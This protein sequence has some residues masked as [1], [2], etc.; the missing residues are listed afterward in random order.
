MV[1]C[2]WDSF[3]RCETTARNFIWTQIRTSFTLPLNTCIYCLA[4]ET[5]NIKKNSCEI[6]FAHSSTIHV[7]MMQNAVTLANIVLE[8]AGV[9]EKTE[10]NKQ[11]KEKRKNHK[12]NLVKQMSAAIQIT[13]N[14]NTNP[15]SL[16]Y[17]VH[18]S[19]SKFCCYKW[20][21]SSL[22]WFLFNTNIVLIFMVF[23]LLFLLYAIDTMFA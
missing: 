9:L 17:F 1:K 20:N 19:P 8:N 23:R 22:L 5:S 4:H 16:V 15:K 13:L 18:C 14:W 12:T 10:N 6:S 21:E 7:D 2:G 3:W 11:N